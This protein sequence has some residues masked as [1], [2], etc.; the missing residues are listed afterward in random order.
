ML[1]VEI[2]YFLTKKRRKKCLFHLAVKGTRRQKLIGKLRTKRK[3]KAILETFSHFP[4]RERERARESPL[5]ETRAELFTH[6]LDGQSPTS[7]G[8]DAV[9]R[10]SVPSFSS[11]QKLRLWIL[12]L[13]SQFDRLV[14]LSCTHLHLLFVGVC[15]FSSK[16]ISI[17]VML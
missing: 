11:F 3:K 8:N 14:R 12:Q 1:Q 5:V 13:S 9:R 4:N 17:L 10:L 7:I 6:S 2:I 16:L 15:L